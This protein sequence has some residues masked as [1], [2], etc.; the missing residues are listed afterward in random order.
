MR[1]FLTSPEYFGSSCLDSLYL[2]LIS[3]GKNLLHKVF[4][5][6]IFKLRMGS[7]RV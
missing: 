6:N 4:V 1:C 2:L 3:F 7:F 5:R